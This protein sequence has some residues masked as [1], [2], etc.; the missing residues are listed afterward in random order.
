MVAIAGEAELRDHLM[1]RSEEYRKLA[2]EHRSFEEQL[3]Q[4]TR[5][6]HLTEQERIREVTLKKMKLALKDQMYALM[7]KYRREIDA[8]K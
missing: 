4:L 1:T 8:G 7:Q 2:A 3:E 5:R 6:H